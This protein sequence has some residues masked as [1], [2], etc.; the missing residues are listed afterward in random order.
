MRA[1]MSVYAGANSSNLAAEPVSHTTYVTAGQPLSHATQPIQLATTSFVGHTSAAAPATVLA[2]NAA[3][4]TPS[5]GDT[6][7]STKILAQMMLPSEKRRATVVAGTRPLSPQQLQIK[8][9]PDVALG[10]TLDNET[11]A[12]AGV[13]E[14][15]IAEKELAKQVS[16]TQFQC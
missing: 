1:R 3:P 16:A 10:S 13:F 7:L 8:A 5:R 2:S 11:W 6:A 9:K 14:A 12:P 15:H 4:C